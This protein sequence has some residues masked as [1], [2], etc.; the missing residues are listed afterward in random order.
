MVESRTTT[1][2]PYGQGD[3]T[4][5]AAGGGAGIRQLVD[6]FYD[7]MASAPAYRRIYNWHPDGDAARDKLARFLC[8]WMGG[9]RRYQ[10]NFGPISI[11]SAH[12]H[13]PITAVERDLWLGCMD[14]ALAHQDYPQE[15]RHYLQEQLR[16]PAEVIRRTCE[17]G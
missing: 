8:G 11:P 7:I 5:Q 10:E 14:E 13:L 16:T 6:H 1:T 12:Q 15:L 17:P 9:P 3:V 4:F 2:A